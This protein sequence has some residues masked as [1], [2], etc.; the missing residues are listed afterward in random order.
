MLINLPVLC[1]SEND[2]QVVIIKRG[3]EGVLSI[4]W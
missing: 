1:Y 2:G 4:Q 3:E